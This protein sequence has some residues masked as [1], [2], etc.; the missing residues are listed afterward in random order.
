MEDAE[1]HEPASA[2]RDRATSSLLR[3]RCSVCA[4]LFR[5]SS[6]RGVDLQPG[7]LP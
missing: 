7:R 3:L 2:T 5:T 6:R 4:T 1:L